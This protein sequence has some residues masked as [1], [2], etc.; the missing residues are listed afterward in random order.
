MATGEPDRYFTVHPGDSRRLDLLLSKKSSPSDPL[1]TCTITS[2]PYANLKNYGHPDQVGWGQDYGDYLAD[3]R[4]IFRSIYRH[5]RHDGSMWVIADTLLDQ[6]SNGNGS[7]VRTLPFDLAKEAEEVGWRL[8]DIIVWE[9]HKTLPWSRRGTLRNSFE[10]ILL[11]V[12]SNDYKYH[13]DRLR[14]P[15]DLAQWWVKWPERYNPL[16]KVPTNVWSIPIPQQGTWGATQIQHACP[17]PP[18]LVERLIFLSTD[19][20]DVVFDPFAGSGSVVA[21]A[22]RLGRRGLGIEIVDKNVRA[23]QKSV[24]PEILDRRGKDEL[25]ERL[26]RSRALRQTIVRLRTLKLAKVVA[27]ELVKRSTEEWRPQSVI[28][29]LESESINNDGHISIT[30]RYVVVIDKPREIREQIK[31]T[32]KDM[33]VDKPM[34]QFGIAPDFVVVAPR[35]VK[36]AIPADTP[37]YLYELGHTWNSSG[38]VDIKTLLGLPPAGRS[39]YPPVAGNVEVNVD[40]GPRR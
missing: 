38:P 25:A 33:M 10:Y 21:E 27:S 30:A 39:K 17:L 18:N 23:Y 13:V 31:Q 32:L 37:L 28:A 36:A 8:R 9:K 22:E 12:K 11:L 5:T 35:G 14:D 6:D 7:A 4:G 20:G 26:E 2:P 1:L 34:S 40:P 15:V 19:E 16:G 29:L 24:R 3:C